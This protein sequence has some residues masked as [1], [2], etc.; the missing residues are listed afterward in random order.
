MRRRGEKEESE[1]RNSLSRI[2][3]GGS[4]TMKQSLTDWI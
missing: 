2:K 1:K 4:V 3:E